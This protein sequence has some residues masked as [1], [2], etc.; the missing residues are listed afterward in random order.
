MGDSAIT[1]T[2]GLGGFVISNAPTFLQMV[3]CTL[4]EARQYTKEMYEI[5]VAKN[6]NFLLPAW[7]FE[8][9]PLGIDIRK[10]VQ[11]NSSPLI[12]TGIA[13]KEGGFIGIGLNRAPMQ[14][15]KDALYAFAEKY[16]EGSDT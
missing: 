13:A 1:E 5:T 9:A 2:I 6:P 4:E 3:G 8:G 7:G 11:T 14:A 16:L 10:V 12:D 15:F